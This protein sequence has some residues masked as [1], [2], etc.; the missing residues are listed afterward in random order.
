M[1]LFAPQDVLPEDFA[2]G[3]FAGRVWR[4]DVNGPSVVRVD[5]DGVTDVTSAGPRC[6]T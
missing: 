3:I 2:D 5:S 6:A 1:T 4:P